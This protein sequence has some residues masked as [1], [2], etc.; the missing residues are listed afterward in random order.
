VSTIALNAHLIALPIAP[1]IVLLIVQSIALR[2]A[3]STARSIAPSTAHSIRHRIAH[4]TPPSIAPP[5]APATAL[6]TA[7]S[8]VLTVVSV[9]ASAI[10][11]ENTAPGITS[12]PSPHGKTGQFRPSRPCYTRADEGVD[13]PAGTRSGPYGLPRCCCV[14]ISNSFHLVLHEYVC[15]SGQTGPNLSRGNKETAHLTDRGSAYPLTNKPTLEHI[16]YAASKL[17]DDSIDEPIL[18]R[19]AKPTDVW[20]VVLIA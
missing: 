5:N 13:M 18:E 6:S 8:I 4:S 16:S 9:I 2:V 1:L 12:G 3:R 15:R 19:I 17:I 10:V 20:I 14:A 11:R 7:S